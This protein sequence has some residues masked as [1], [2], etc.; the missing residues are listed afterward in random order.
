MILFP[1]AKINLGLY[2]TEKRAD[3]YHNIES[4]FFPIPYFDSLEINTADTFSLKVYG[5]SIAGKTEDNL[6]YKAWHLLHTAFQIPAVSIHLVKH[7]ASGAGLGGGSADASF[8]LNALKTHFNLDLSPQ[9]LQH[10]AEK[11]GSD[12]PFFIQNTPIIASGKGEIMQPIQINL[13]AYYL[14]LYLPNLHVSTQEAYQGVKP[15][16]L[17]FSLKNLLESAPQQWKNILHNQFEDHIF[18]LYP[19]LEE[20]KEELYKKGA[21][22]AAMSGSGSTLFG[23]FPAEPT[24]EKYQDAA[25]KVFKL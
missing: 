8:T 3:G 12:C 21:L 5:N 10:F 18:Q 13:S 7:I 4:G 9:K 22:Y 14:A 1:N 16:K 11:L 23:I 2:I 15:K 25:L 24:L 20:L 19:R 17:E 6:V